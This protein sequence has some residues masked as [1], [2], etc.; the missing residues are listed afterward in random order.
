VLHGA[1][2]DVIPITV[3]ERL[4]DLVRAPKRFVRFPEGGHC[5]LDAC[6]ALAVVRDF[7]ASLRTGRPPCAP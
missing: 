3:G 1:R 2:D 4:Y 7:L 5:D 6:G